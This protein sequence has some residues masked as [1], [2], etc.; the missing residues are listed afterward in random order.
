[1]PFPQK[2]QIALDFGGVNPDNCSDAGPEGLLD[3][4]VKKFLAEQRE[5]S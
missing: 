2:N 4:S 5:H 1:M 3:T